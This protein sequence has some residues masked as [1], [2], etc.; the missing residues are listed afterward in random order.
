[1]VG[2]QPGRHYFTRSASRQVEVQVK[3]S[4]PSAP[5]HEP[6]EREYDGNRELLKHLGAAINEQFQPFVNRLLAID[7]MN[8]GTIPVPS[9][10]QHMIHDYKL[11][12]EYLNQLAFS[13]DLQRTQAVHYKQLLKDLE[14]YLCMD[15][16]KSKR[17][18]I[19]KALKKLEGSHEG[20]AKLGDFC[21]MLREV[22][23]SAP[24]IDTVLEI[25]QPSEGRVYF[26]PLLAKLK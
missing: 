14:S 13:Y 3:G 20:Y 6:A 10:V 24:D 9:F 23:I 19:K 17:K 16:V 7:T 18:N 1:M 21:E 22:G 15:R 25:C 8:T 11:P 26:P 2:D 12:E 5:I 4:G